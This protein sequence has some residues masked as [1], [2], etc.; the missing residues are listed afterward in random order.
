MVSRGLFTVFPDVAL[1]QR[2]QVFIESK[3]YACETC[4]KGHRSSACK[5]TDRPLFEIK[6]KGRPVTQ[7]EHCRELRKTKQVHVKC[8]CEIKND[9]SVAPK[10][11]G[12]KASEGA[13]FP[14]GLP[15]ALAMEASVAQLETPSSSSIHGAACS[16]E[17]TA[18]CPCWTPRKSA[19]RP[20]RKTDAALS[21][22][23]VTSVSIAA[24]PAIVAPVQQQ[25]HMPPAPT[26]RDVQ[27]LNEA[28]LDFPRASSHILA[29][30]SELRPVLPRPTAHHDPSSGIAHGHHSIRHHE[31]AFFSPYGRAYDI[32]HPH[33]PHTAD[34][35]TA[36]RFSIGDPAASKPQIFDRAIANSI[37]VAPAATTN[38]AAVASTS[39]PSSITFPSPCGCG[40][41]CSCPG[42]SHHNNAPFGPSPTAYP[43]CSNPT[44]CHA[45]LDCT[46]LSLPPDTALSIPEQQQ[47]DMIDEW[48]RQVQANPDSMMI[49]SMDGQLTGWDN[50][51]Q[52][53]AGRRQC[54]TCT[55]FFCTCE[56]E[57]GVDRHHH[58][59]HEPSNEVSCCDKP[60]LVD[61][62]SGQ[63]QGR[64]GVAA[65]AAI[66][67]GGYG[68]SAPDF[69][70]YSMLGMQPS[71]DTS[72]YLDTAAIEAFRS[73]SPSISPNSI[74]HHHHEFS[75][76]MFTTTAAP[77]FT[78]Y[79][80]L[81]DKMPA[82]QQSMYINGRGF[83]SDP[84]LSMSS[85]SNGANNHERGSSG[86]GGG[87]A[88]GFVLDTHTPFLSLPL[89]DVDYPPGTYAVSNPDSD[90]SS[91]DSV[92]DFV[93]VPSSSQ[94]A[95]SV[96]HQHQQQTK[97]SSV[98]PV[99]VEGMRTLY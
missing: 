90:T 1:T 39:S 82:S 64:G 83:Y 70:D 98:S 95:V 21:A 73:R 94:R 87:G 52:L 89:S 55:S 58:H 17:S 24:T 33:H 79:S 5:H 99:S 45:C 2:T 43:T 68:S 86:G 91:F 76:Q 97:R 74:H 27:M 32:N 53:T 42:C 11:V 26:N 3:K 8:I 6:K 92:E 15:E 48:I 96:V 7:C 4:I 69:F 57:V 20:R 44:S 77:S 88:D 12:T 35:N 50:L 72:S 59:H 75:S 51:A 9:S 29:R 81:V 18:T 63:G 66:A 54:A 38:A 34:D 37:P 61:M 31:N 80:A 23:S 85:N 22:A 36:Q 16:C 78:P 93:S 25:Q 14:N 84:Y 13:A 56:K 47:A 10:K 41:G 62:G 71:N 67:A 28:P 30:I 19:P 46:I 40:D 49:S 60:K 65:A